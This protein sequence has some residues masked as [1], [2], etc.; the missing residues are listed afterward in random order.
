MSV[1]DALLAYTLAA[2]LL[3]LTPGLDTAL[4]LRTAAADG[5]KKAFQAALGID[6]GCF[7]WGALVAFGLGALFAVSEM[8]YSILKWCGAGYLCWLGIQLLLRPRTT[9]DT[10]QGDETRASNSFLRGMLGN[11]LNPKMGVFYV[12]FLPQFIPTGHSPMVWTFLLVAIHALIG[13]LWSLTLIVATRYASGVLK[14]TG[15]VK[16]MDRVTGS[17]FLLFAAKLALSKR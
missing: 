1:T 15:V 8:A 10:R 4:I 17:V 11:V 16:W 12:S 9:F 5:G 14:K 3:T 6:A 2:T 13:T 7:V